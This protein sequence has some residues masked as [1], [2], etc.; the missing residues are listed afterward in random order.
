MSPKVLDGPAL[1]WDNQPV[2]P[3]ERICG[4][5]GTT[6]KAETGKGS[7]CGHVSPEGIQT[8]EAQPLTVLKPKVKVQYLK[9]IEKWRQQ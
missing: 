1:P 7:P 3:P 6:W 9:R 4:I 5:C 2:G 8:I